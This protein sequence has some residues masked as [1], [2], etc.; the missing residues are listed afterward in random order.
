[1]LRKALGLV[2]VL[3]VGGLAV[4]QPKG[5]EKD[6]DGKKPVGVKA[7]VTKVDVDK[8]LLDVT[9]DGKKHSFAVTKATHFFGPKGGKR[10]KGIRDEVLKVGAEVRVV[11][12]STSKML[13][14]VHLPTK[15][16][17]DKDKPKKKETGTK[18]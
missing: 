8:H 16:R 7:I 13:K 15:S 1:M 3:L 2:V 5:K 9:I 12:D 14:E 17:K 18:E 4:G 6:K 11:I 10:E